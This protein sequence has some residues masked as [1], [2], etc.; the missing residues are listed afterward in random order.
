MFINTHVLSFII[1]YFDYECKQLYQHHKTSSVTVFIYMCTL[2]V[3]IDVPTMVTY[4]RTGVPRVVRD[5]H[6]LR[7]NIS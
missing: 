3:N 5:T 7:S 6:V 4:G 1:F 2:R